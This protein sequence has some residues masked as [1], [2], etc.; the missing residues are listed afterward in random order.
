MFAVALDADVEGL[1]TAGFCAAVNSRRM[2]HWT[3]E[4]VSFSGR[5]R[6][7]AKAGED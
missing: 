4:D 1:Q 7:E 2:D 6:V 3:A 5:K